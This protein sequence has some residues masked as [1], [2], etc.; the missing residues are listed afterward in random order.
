MSNENINDYLKE[1]KKYI[2]KRTEI[3]GNALTSKYVIHNCA[4]KS[5]RGSEGAKANVPW[6]LAVAM[7]ITPPRWCRGALEPAVGLSQ[8]WHRCDPVPSQEQD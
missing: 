1:I 7:V 2:K 5:I 8:R 4:L 3:Y 6:L